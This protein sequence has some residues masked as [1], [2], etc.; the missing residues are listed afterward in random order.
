VRACKFNR[1]AN[2]GH[3]MIELACVS[4]L[5][6]IASLIAADIGI[7]MLADST[8]ERAARDAAR[9]AASASDPPSGLLMAQAAAATHGVASPFISKPTVLPAS[10]VYQDFAGT[11]PPDTSPYVE[12]TTEISVKLPAPLFFVQ[13]K[14]DMSSSTGRMVLRKRYHFP[15]IKTKLYLR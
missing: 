2:S 6:V 3:G 7:I 10:Y 13:A 14:L 12:V 5:L 11:P 1:R 8:N 15:I 4:L 9:A